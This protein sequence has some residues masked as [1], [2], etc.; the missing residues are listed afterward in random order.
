MRAMNKRMQSVDP[1]DTQN[2]QPTVIESM[3]TL[4]SARARACVWRKQNM[5]SHQNIY[6]TSDRRDVADEPANNATV[7]L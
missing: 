5:T 3:Y 1:M 6:Y 4:E 2:K 7:G